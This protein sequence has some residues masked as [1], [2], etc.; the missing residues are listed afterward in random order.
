MKTRLYKRI[1]WMPGRTTANSSAS[2]GST[3]TAGT[4]AGVVDTKGADM[5]CLTVARD[6][7]AGTVKNIWRFASGSAATNTYAQNTAHPALTGSTTVN[8][9]SGGGWQ[10]WVDLRSSTYKRF[11]TCL[12]SA[13]TGSTHTQV[14]ADLYKQETYPAG[15]ATGAAGGNGFT[16]VVEA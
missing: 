9:L 1:A 4:F 16:T 5:L 11:W 14:L 8:P 7:S 12:L 3:G 10:A 6:V 2:A 13:V 15:S